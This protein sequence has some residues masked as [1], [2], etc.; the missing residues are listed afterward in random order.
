[1]AKRK[2]DP[3]AD[4]ADA[5]VCLSCP[6]PFCTGSDKCFRS[7]KRELN[8]GRTTSEPRETV[9]E[10]SKTGTGGEQVEA[11]IDL[12]FSFDLPDFDGLLDDLD[13]SLDGLDFDFDLPD[14]LPLNRERTARKLPVEDC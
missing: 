10:Q 13:L 1:M 6:L 14:D 11:V 12:D 2:P 3:E 5:L 8:H 7:R 4:R 9:E